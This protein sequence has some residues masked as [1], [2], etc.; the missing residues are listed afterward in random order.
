MRRA[1]LIFGLAYLWT[2]IASLWFCL[3]NL[4]LFTFPF[5]QWWEGLYYLHNMLWMPRFKDIGH[6][7]L[8]WFVAG[9]IVATLAIIVLI[10]PA[11]PRKDRQPNLYGKSE[12]AGLKAMAEGGITTEKRP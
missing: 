6:W 10:R 12:F 9:F 4:R 3:F 7:P 11:L 8:L 1:A 5:V 2:V